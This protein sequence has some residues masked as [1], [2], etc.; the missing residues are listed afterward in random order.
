MKGVDDVELLLVVERSRVGGGGGRGRRNRDRSPFDEYDW[1]FWWGYE[2]SGDSKVS[3][4]SRTRRE[5]KVRVRS[6]R[7]DDLVRKVETLP[8]LAGTFDVED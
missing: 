6:E 8:R 2:A 4:L 5:V 7:T 3:K 1:E